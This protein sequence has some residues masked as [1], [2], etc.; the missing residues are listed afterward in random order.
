MY[1][2]NDEIILEIS[3]DGLK[4]YMSI[5]NS[6]S[7]PM[8]DAIKKIDDY[9]K[10]GLNKELAYNLLERNE[11]IDR[12]LIAEGTSPIDG[13]NGHI[14]YNFET[15]R[16]LMPKMNK[17]GTVDYRELDSINKVSNGEVLAKIILPTLGIE[18]KKVTGES[19]PA[20]KGKTP[21][22][23]NGKNTIVSED[24]LNLKSDTDGLVEVKNGKID[25]LEI[26]NL[27]YVDNSV[28]NIDFSGNVIIDKDILN[29]FSVK[30]KGSVEIRGAVEGGYIQCQGDVLVRRGIQGYNRI[31]VESKGNLCTKFIENACIN[32]SGNITSES[33]MHSNVTSKSNILLLGKNGLIVGGICRAN[34]EIRAKVIGS[35][36]ATKTILEV[37][38]DPDIKLRQETL[39]KELEASDENLEKLN[40][41][42]VVLDRLK[43]SNKLDAK[44]QSLYYDLLSAKET[45]YLE[46]KKIKND[47]L[48][49]REKID[50]LSKGQIKVSDTIYPGTKI[51]IG[52]SYL[53]IKRK[54]Q[55]CRFYNENGEIR[56]GAY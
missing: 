26:L 11:A 20:K 42:L 9:I 29:G 30:S 25:V 4:A 54:M 53:N 8:E 10:Y 50:T 1:K 51:V 45:I 38:I 3:R 23:K 14:E 36:M 35:S 52:N 40:K 2:I 56:V 6:N 48:L 31:T 18:G 34:N 47:L 43:R 32:V 46:N 13:K 24:G 19:I 41:S 16:A 27:D 33:I 39:E 15:K 21:K 49:I 28:G 44:K 12:V 37:G 22:F 7:Y 5:L 55:N 17:D